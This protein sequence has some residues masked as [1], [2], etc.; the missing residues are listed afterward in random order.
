MKG[1]ELADQ[2]K[3]RKAEKNWPQIV[4]VLVACLSSLT[5]GLFLAWPSPFILKITQDKENYAISEDQAS[6]FTIF[7]VVGLIVFPPFLTIFN[8]PD[9]IGRKPTIMLTAIPHM[10]S[11][12]L[13]AFC[14]DLYLLYLARFTSGLGDALVFASLPVYIG[15]ITTPKVRGIW[16]N[17]L[18]C[19]IFLGQFL[20]NA[21]GSYCNVQETSFI[22]L[23]VPVILVVALT[24]IPES[25]YF[26][27]MTG[28]DERAEKSLQKLRGI[29]DIEKELLQLKAAVERQMSETGT[30]KDLVMVRSNRR[31]LVALVFLRFSQVTSGIF[32]FASYMQFIFEKAGGEIEPGVSSMIYMGLTF[33]IYSGGTYVCDKFGRKKS[34]MISM[35]LSGMHVQF[36]KWNVRRLAITFHCQDH[37]RQGEL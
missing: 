13:I 16:G 33:I 8:I 32:V 34:Y 10:I 3:L 31:A 37:P 23:T 17:G 18:I 36:D 4:A 27:V 1:Q 19:S 29:D 2:D 7:N 24:F 12:I 15:E 6:Y 22:C 9:V 11:W 20:M 14:T 35:A 26:Y 21:I 28:K 30:W 5:S 25:P